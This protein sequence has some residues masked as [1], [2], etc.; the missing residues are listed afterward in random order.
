MDVNALH[1][2]SQEIGIFFY[3]SLHHHDILESQRFRQEILLAQH[4][5]QSLLPQNPPQIEGLALAG[6]YIPSREIGGDYYDFILKE[7][8]LLTSVEKGVYIV[9]GDVSGKGLD[10]GF[11]VSS[12]K[13]FLTSLIKF[14]DSPKEILGMVN[15]DI[16]NSLR[17]QKFISLLLLNYISFD[18]K[19]RYSSAGHERILI[20]RQENRGKKEE[21]EI[22]VSGGVILGM[23]E[24][25]E[26]YLEEREIELERGD[27]ILLYTDG[28]TEAR[29]P[30]GEMYG[31]GRLVESFRRHSELRVEEMVNRVYQDIRDFISTYPQYDDITLVGIEKE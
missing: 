27:K 29:S 30:E 5:Q 18:G 2:L 10:A 21:I 14:C 6:L 7:T 24:E 3:T 12:V 19:M 22:L 11:I 20:A 31:L 17:Q 23:I 26:F 1:N 25:I 15:R 9:I 28:A 16:Y 13:S 8:G 4:I